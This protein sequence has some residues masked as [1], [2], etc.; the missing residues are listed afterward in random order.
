VDRSDG[1]LARRGNRAIRAVLMSVGDNLIKCNR[2][3]RTMA[4]GWKTDGCDPRLIHTRVAMRFARIAFHIVSGR[5]VFRHPCTQDRSYILQ[6][7]IA[8]HQEHKTPMHQVLTDS[9]NAIEQLPPNAHASEA[10]VLCDELGNIRSRRSRGEQPI[11]EILPEVLARLGAGNV[12]FEV[13]G[14]A[15]PA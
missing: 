14:G 8:F 5:Q 11:G 2:Y 12:Q 9:Q 1:S 10:K 6:K 4:T 3:F 15:T 13:S 7:L